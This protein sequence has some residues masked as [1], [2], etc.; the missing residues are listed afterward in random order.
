M[1]QKKEYKYKCENCK[2]Y[3]NEISK[4]EKHIETEK[5]KT[6]KRSD[7]KGGYKCD[8]CNYETINKITFKQH[9]LNEHS[10]KSER[11][12]EFKYYCIMCDYGTFSIDLY[13]RHKLTKKHTLKE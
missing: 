1:D 2:F 5:H 3:C 4:W 13:D 6:G 10:T 9:I 7:Y 12:K 8:K 11:E